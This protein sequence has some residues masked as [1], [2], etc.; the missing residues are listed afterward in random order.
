MS[1]R[2]VCKSRFHLAL[3]C[4]L[5]TTVPSARGSDLDKIDQALER[6]TLSDLK[7]HCGT[8]AS[9]ALE[10]RE[11]GTTGS[12]AAAAYL[13]TE[14][15]KIEPLKGATAAGWIQEFGSFQ[16]LIAV[17]PG[18]DPVLRDEIVLIGAH[19][20]HVGRGNQ[21]NSHGPFGYIHNGADDNASGTAALLE[22]AD[23]FASMSPAPKRTL[24]F[25]FWDA[26]EMGLLGSAHWVKQPTH[27]LKAIRQVINIDMLGRLRDGGVVVVGWRSAPGLRT[28]LVRQNHKGD[29]L[30]R[31][32][33]KVIADSDH[34]P[35]YTSGIP[36]VHLDTG[37]HDD[38]HRPS[39]DADKLNY[40][41]ILRLAEFVFRLAHEVANE[42]NLPAFRREALTELP[43]AWLTTR[44]PAA[45]RLGVGFD[46][47]QI[48]NDRAVVTEVTAG[49]A[50]LKGGIRSGDR[51]VKLA[52]WDSGSVADL[53]T[54][55]RVAQN[56]VTV[57]IERPGAEAPIELQLNLAGDP[58]RIGI[59]WE[60]DPAI[61]GSVT[62][63]NVIPDSPADRAGLKAGDVV[64]KLG[65]NAIIS[66]EDFRSHL[67][68]DRGPLDFQVERDGVLKQISVKLY[69][70]VAE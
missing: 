10:G 4:F 25:A 12:R 23:A 9:D 15:R 14:L 49:S 58:V 32:E 33:P 21:T 24:V 16:N 52:H 7:R 56:P 19:Y 30:F 55:V 50:A 27:P 36:V 51:L 54:I 3:I 26:E 6:I 11:A 2:S 8:L 42:P 64:N 43:P 46:A 13:Q 38:Y 67:L 41:G 45:V 53:K 59:V 20:D 68:H 69:S 1:D 37:K 31:Y 66:D 5:M 47:E 29:L 44:Q 40:Q 60:S 70:P 63:T 57:V 48:K 62:I 65:E 28:R 34:Y 61:P 35:F 17:L 39:D 18:S 22:L